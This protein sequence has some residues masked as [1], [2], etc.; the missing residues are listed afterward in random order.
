MH[1]PEVERRGVQRLAV[2]VPITIWDAGSTLEMSGITRDVSSR[3]VFFLV[4]SWPAQTGSLEFMFTLDPSTSGL[5]EAMRVFCEGTVVRVEKSGFQGRVGVAVAI[6]R[7]RLRGQYGLT[8]GGHKY[9][10]E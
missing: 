1:Q 3:G 4:T 5:S 6:E 7:Y 8:L 2:Q 9:P 10:L